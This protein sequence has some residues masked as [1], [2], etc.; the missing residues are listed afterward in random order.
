MFLS[1]AIMKHYI[2]YAIKNNQIVHIS[3]VESG[4]AC[5]S[6]C[7]FCNSQLVAKKG[8]KV[9]HHFAHYN[10]VECDYAFESSLHLG[11]KRVLENE[12]KFLFPPLIGQSILGK[13]VTL[14]K[15]ILLQID[16]IKIESRIGSIIPDILIILGSSM[17]ILE[18]YVTHKVDYEKQRKIE[19]MDIAAIEIDFSQE[20]RAL[21]D[22]RIRD[23]LC[24]NISLKRWIFNPKLKP[25]TIELNKHLKTKVEEGL[26]DHFK[27]TRVKHCFD[28][29]FGCP[30][31]PKHRKN[32]NVSLHEDSYD[33]D[34]YI[35]HTDD[36]VLYCSAR[37]TMWEKLNKK[38]SKGDLINRTSKFEN[39]QSYLEKLNV[40]PECGNMLL[41]RNGIRGPF[42]A[43]KGFPDCRYT[44]SID[45]NTGELF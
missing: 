1:R 13:N 15:S 25:L 33:C 27:I 30:L 23:I 31:L 7:T 26:I 10:Q 21:D 37:Y 29:I 19:K 9:V 41:I 20:D 2:Q 32:W 36:N 16:S 17:C 39:T 12:R 22:E 24:N 35:S 18:I 44:R 42:L 40:C 3:E 4:L 14:K 45:P 34:Y 8:T 6:Y 11:V 28:A 43:C 5:G 38:W